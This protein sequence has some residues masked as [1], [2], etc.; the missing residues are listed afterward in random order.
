MTNEEIQGNLASMSDLAHAH[1][2]KVVFS[3]VTPISEY[4]VRGV[5]QTT[6]SAD[7]AHQGDERVDQVVRGLAW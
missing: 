5:P 6:D 2:I 3:S 4:H 1:N 7:G